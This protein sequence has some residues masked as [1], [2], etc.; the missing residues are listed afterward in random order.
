MSGH[1]FQEV[2]IADIGIGTHFRQDLGDIPGLAASIA[3]IGAALIGSGFLTPK[4][5][6]PITVPYQ[7]V[8]P[9]YRQPRQTHC[10]TDRLGFTQCTTY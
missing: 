10:Y 3:A 9:P 5:Q 7:P 8:P 6:A 1:R 2:P 4:P